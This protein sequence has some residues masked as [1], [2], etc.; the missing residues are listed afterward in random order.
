[1][2]V[3]AMIG[4]LRDGAAAL[5]LPVNIVVVSDHG[6]QDLDKKKVAVI[7]E[8]PDAARILAKFQ[9]M[10]RGPQMLLYLNK[11]EDRSV[12]ADA[13][14]ILIKRAGKKYHVWRRDQL[15]KLHYDSTPRT[16]DLVIEPQIP[17]VVVTRAKPPNAEGA[18]HGWDPNA[19]A[20]QGIFFAV[21]PAFKE[22]ARIP[23]FENIHVYPLLLEVLGLHQRVPI[24]G[25]LEN[26]QG[27]LRVDTK[28]SSKA[29]K[30]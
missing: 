12:I 23:T 29:T 21:G 6:M 30:H 3:D 26:L 14:A 19:K 13:Q 16:G 17:Y 10:G 25:H 11:G 8:T 27:A 22:H 5:K 15:A 2:R 24:D 20:M 4:R 18:N 7:D 1:M 9:T 28:E